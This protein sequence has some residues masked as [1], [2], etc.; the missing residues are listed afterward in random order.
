MDE[1][2]YCQLRKISNRAFTLGY[3]PTDSELSTLFTEF[4]KL[5]ATEQEPVAWRCWDMQEER[6][7][8]TT[9][10]KRLPA[11]EPL[12]AAPLDL[13]KRIA[14]LEAGLKHAGQVVLPSYIETEKGLL[15][16]RDQLATQVTMLREALSLYT[17]GDNELDGLS[18]YE[19][20]TKALT[21]TSDDWLKRHDAEVR[22]ATLEEVAVLATVGAT[23]P[24]L[25]QFL[26]AE[27]E[28]EKHD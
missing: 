21:A 9:E 19:A 23:Y 12:Y 4:Q 22:H 24:E 17:Y 27:L 15:A 3:V 1:S 11:G 13:T 6:W 8:I 10:N 16:D 14:E 26:K 20:G 5:Q 7:R 2:Q 18:L 28:G 25:M